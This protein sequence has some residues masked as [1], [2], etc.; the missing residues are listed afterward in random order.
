MKRALQSQSSLKMWL[1]MKRN[2]EISQ[3]VCPST[4]HPSATW[5]VVSVL[6][7]HVALPGSTELAV[8]KTTTPIVCTAVIRA[9]FTPNVTQR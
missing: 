7:Q 8:E 3:D 5:F 1:L 2:M 4:G 9:E 6:I